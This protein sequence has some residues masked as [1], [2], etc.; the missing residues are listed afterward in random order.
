MSAAELQSWL[1]VFCNVKKHGRV[2]GKRMR[3]MI[4]MRM[5]SMT[6]NRVRSTQRILFNDSDTNE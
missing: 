2:T 4:G 6:G 5:R 3:S 1:K